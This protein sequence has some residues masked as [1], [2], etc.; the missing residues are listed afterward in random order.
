M[1]LLLA[2][3]IVFSVVIPGLVG[4]AGMNEREAVSGESFTNT[5]EYVSSDE[6]VNSSA[7]VSIWERAALPLRVDTSTATTTVDVP[8]TFVNVT[9]QGDG[10]L[11]LNKRTLGVFNTSSTISV[12]LVDRT[13]ANTTQFAGEDVQLVVARL[14]ETGERPNTSDVNS[15]MT[16]GEA[17][18]RLVGENLSSEE[19]NS[20]FTFLPTKSDQIASDGSVSFDVQP[21]APGHY[22]FVLVASDDGNAVS[23]QDGNVTSVDDG[24]RILGVD[25]APVQAAEASA[26]P[27]EERVPRGENATFTLD[28]NLDADSVNHTVVVFNESVLRNQRTTITIEDE[29]DG[30]LSSENVTIEHSVES[31]DGVAHIDSGTS[32]M[33]TDL[34]DRT[35]DQSVTLASVIDRLA[36]ETNQT[37]PTTTATDDVV[38]NASMTAVEASNSTTLNVTTGENWTNGSYT[39]LYIAST[40]DSS[41]FSTTRGSMTVGPKSLNPVQLEI[42]ADKTTVKVDGTVQ[43]TVTRPDDTPVSGANV[44]FAG[45][46][47]QTDANG[48]ASIKPSQAG[49]VPVSVSKANT[50]TETFLSDSL[51]LSVER[52]VAELSVSVKPREFTEGD[53][54]TVTVT[55]KSGGA[56]SDAQVTVAG[57]T[58]TTN[59]NG[60]ATISPTKTGK[61][62]VK[63]NKSNTRTTTFQTATTKITVNAAGGG[64]G[65]GGGGQGGGSDGGSANPVPTNN[66]ATVNFRDMRGGQL[67]SVDLPNVASG[68]AAVTGM[69]ITT[70]FSQGDFRVEF[71]KPEQNPPQ[72]TP[73]LDRSKGTASQYFTAEAI[74]VT[75]D[76][77]DNVKFTFTLEESEIREGASK[78]DVRLFRYVD[79]EWTT[80]ETTHLGGDQYRATSPGFTAYAIGV[81]AEQT[82]TETETETVTETDTDTETEPDADPETDTETPSEPGTGIG[83]TALIGILVVLVLIGAGAYLYTN[84]E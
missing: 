52:E 80:L 20:N 4:A 57:S 81:Q 61:L 54:A 64:G 25:G 67:V 62:T 70:R 31:V 27:S 58:V 26:T 29:I 2:A 36:N 39:Y 72:G 37:A 73:E 44:T 5:A 47:V 75:D 14:N 77:L 50:T 34:S 76:R 8:D 16:T 48:Q 46:T 69:E 59:T 84:R 82:D 35:V 23:V 42:T 60:K 28:S 10:E 49:S 1:A 74:G 63:V 51:T 68:Q 15:T 65:G 18:D 56:V 83:S 22:A 3:L 79:G 19:V 9:T 33:G 11:S 24:A 32:V 78:D 21:D 13:G 53:K 41:Q 12:D 55:R 71:T 38:L 17:I 7:N 66:G 30:N 45:N 43:V 40:D 6:F